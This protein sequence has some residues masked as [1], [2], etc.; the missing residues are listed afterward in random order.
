MLMTAQ[1][2]Q[3]IEDSDYLDELITVLE[4]LSPTHRQQVFDF[5]E[6]LAHKN[7]QSS[8]TATEEN[9]VAEE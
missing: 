5:M 7:Q 1:I 4:T 2:L 3:P 6:F 9:K 8:I